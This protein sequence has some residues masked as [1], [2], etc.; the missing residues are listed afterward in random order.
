MYCETS[1]WWRQPNPDAKQLPQ[2][3]AQRGDKAPI[4]I[5]KES[6]SLRWLRAI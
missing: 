5:Q 1:D 6:Q 3:S 2:S 4:F